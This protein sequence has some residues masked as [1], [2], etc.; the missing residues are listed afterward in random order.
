MP[1]RNVQHVT[2]FRDFQPITS[3]DKQ[4]ACL[5]MFAKW[6]LSPLYQ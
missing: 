2:L 3:V 6:T 4:T 1:G 5:H